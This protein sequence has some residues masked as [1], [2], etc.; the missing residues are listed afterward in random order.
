MAFPK[1]LVLLLV[2]MVWH[3]VHSIER[4]LSITHLLQ[5]GLGMERLQPPTRPVS[6]KSF[7]P[8]ALT[9]SVIPTANLR[10]SLAYGNNTGD[11]QEKIGKKDL[12][13]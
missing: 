6:K 13:R 2:L 8:E 4:V 3:P 5:T 11:E 1:F 9:T 12:M 7:E 10:G